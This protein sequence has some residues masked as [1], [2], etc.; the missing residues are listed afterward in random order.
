[1]RVAYL[2]SFKDNLSMFPTGGR[3]I[4][5]SRNNTSVWMNGEGA[6]A[7]RCESALSL[8]DDRLQ[9]AEAMSALRKVY[10]AVSAVVDASSGLRI[11]IHLGGLSHQAIVKCNQTLFELVGRMGLTDVEFYCISRTNRCPKALF[12]GNGNYAPPSNNAIQDLIKELKSEINEN[13]YEHARALHLFDQLRLVHKDDSAWLMMLQFELNR[14]LT[15]DE[16]EF[17]RK[18]FA[19]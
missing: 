11:F 4:V 5:S 18:E 13:K 17:M 16:K 10:S 6:Y 1:M 14:A 7:W 2:I 19:K 15:T 12:N 3:C 8:S 9:S